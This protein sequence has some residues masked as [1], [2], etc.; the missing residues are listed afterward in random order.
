MTKKETALLLKHIYVLYPNNFPIDEDVLPAMIETWTEVLKDRKY[1]EIFERLI[2]YAK[3]NR[4]P[5]TPAD[6]CYKEIKPP[7]FEEYVHDPN[8]GEDW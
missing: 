3:E 1:E 5:P 8:A 2:Q 4:F 6:L 7:Y